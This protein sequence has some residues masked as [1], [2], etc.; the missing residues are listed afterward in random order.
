MSSKVISARSFLPA[1]LT[2]TPVP[3]ADSSA[4]W[5]LAIASA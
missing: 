1:G 4:S 5:P 2:L 3:S